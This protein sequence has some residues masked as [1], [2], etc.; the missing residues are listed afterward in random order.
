MKIK[1]SEY[2]EVSTTEEDMKKLFESF[3][4]SKNPF[5]SRIKAIDAKGNE[6]VLQEGS[7]QGMMVVSEDFL[8]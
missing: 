1:I 3:G 7:S 2:K 5:K 4:K 8:K 6:R